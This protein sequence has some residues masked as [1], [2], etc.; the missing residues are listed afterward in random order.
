MTEKSKE[1]SLTTYWEWNDDV[2]NP[3]YIYMQQVVLTFLHALM[4]FR[5]GVQNCGALAANSGNNKLA[6]FFYAR[7]HPKYQRMNIVEE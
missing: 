2:I 3:N 4:L 7:N 6:K 5:V 1:C